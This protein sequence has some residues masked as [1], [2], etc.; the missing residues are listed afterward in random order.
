MRA[1][2]VPFP[3]SHRNSPAAIIHLLKKVSCN[4]IL[5]TQATLSSL[6]NNIKGDIS[7]LNPEFE[8]V[9]DT[10]PTFEQLYP[11]LGKESMQHPFDYYPPLHSY[12]NPDDVILYLHSS[13]STGFP[14]P[15]PESVRGLTEWASNHASSAINKY[16]ALRIGAMALPAFH[17]LG[18]CAQVIYTVYGLICVS[19]FPPVVKSPDDQPCLPTSNNILEH[20]RRTGSNGLIIIPTLLR[21]IVE[22]PDGV[23][24]LRHFEFVSYGGGPI[25]SKLGD[26]LEA[27]GVNLQPIYGATETGP[28][29]VIR[30]RQSNS[31][32]WEWMEF[33]DRLH[34]RWILQGDGTYE[35]Q[36]L[37]CNTQ[38]PSVENMDDVKG[39]TTSDTF[40]QHPT[41][42]QYWRIVGRID[43]VIIHSSGEKTVPAPMESILLSYP[44]IR[45]AVMFGH[46]HDQAGV[47]LEVMGE[48]PI[49]VNNQRDVARVRGQVW[50]IIEEANKSLPAYSRVF[51]EM[52]LIASP[53]K[54]LPRTAKGTVIRKSALKLYE[55]EIEALYQKMETS[56]VENVSAPIAWEEQTVASWLLKQASDIQSSSS[57]EPGTDLFDQG[58][59]SLSAT[60][61]RLRIV[62]ALRQLG[63]HVDLPSLQNIVYEHPTID[64]LAHR[65]S[66]IVSDPEKGHTSRSE[67]DIIEDMVA[68]YSAGLDEPIHREAA[69]SLVAG[70]QVVLI[71]GTTGNL[72]S[73]I[74]E[75]L[76][77]NDQVERVYALNRRSASGSTFIRIEQKF[78]DKGLDTELLHLSKLVV[79]EGDAAQDNL[80]LSLDVYAEVQ[81]LVTMIIHVAWRLDF[82]LTLASFEP[83]IRGTRHL[84]DLARGGPHASSLRLLYTSSIASAQAWGADHG[85]YPEEVVYDARYAVGGGYGES[86]YVGERVLANSGLRVT[87]MRLGQI[88]G[89][90]P[91]G[92]W[93]TSDWVPILV[94][95]SLALGAMPDAVGVTSWLPMDATARS[96][97]DIAFSAKPFPE[98]LNMV[99]PRPVE[100]RD[101]MSYIRL[102][103]TKYL[104]VEKDSLVTLPFHDWISLVESRAKNANDD[105]LRKIPAI[106][107]IDFYRGMA[108][109]DD[110]IRISG[111][112]SAESG[113]LAT[114]A[115]EK[116]QIYSATL[117]SI[118]ASYWSD[119][120]F[121]A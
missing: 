39:Y 5:T 98:A 14:K 80:G 91:N 4:R 47:L 20:L 24:T 11:K 87:S 22:C 26:S 16:P 9:I 19:V 69:G 65:M 61:L 108:E 17:S 104:G 88:S 105:D 2:L 121:L 56:N 96:I 6:M 45:G 48:V 111:H 31:V 99:H 37:T 3:I 12:L 110:R 117:S 34:T 119:A 42:K 118:R 50:P 13:G 64:S 75:R 76:L 71:T 116:A 10:M 73:Q 68:K 109:A 83:N 57:L 90:A 60:F 54:P 100:W 58:F 46:K 21:E 40:V 102:T 33:G 55:T 67:V 44:T 29:T 49:D 18:F 112:I 41:L 77:Q 25:G 93:A 107:L 72:G 101:T 23:D 103:L 79:L 95:S 15:I 36:Y 27:S 114:L 7:Q 94:K 113:G 35:L 70:K 1:G 51:K 8:L 66:E 97:L 78:I 115:T 28:T 32:H 59:D 85:P 92:A 120:G 81:Q 43:D 74:L 84:V 106:K 53:T 89:G 62:G 63:T 86:K 30:P 82:N 38:H 52:V